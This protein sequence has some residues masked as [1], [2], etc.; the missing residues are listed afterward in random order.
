MQA[1]RG[2]RSSQLIAVCFFDRREYDF[3]TLRGLSIRAF[4]L[5]L[6]LYGFG[7]VIESYWK[8]IIVGCK[9]IIHCPVRWMAV[10][11]LP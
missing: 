6:C 9:D 5:K 7:M 8:V 10:V 4:R 11:L 2:R 1:R 3:L